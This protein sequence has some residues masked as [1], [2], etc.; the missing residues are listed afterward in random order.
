MNQKKLSGGTVS[1]FYF[2]CGCC[3]HEIF[4]KNG[5]T[6]SNSPK[7][8]RVVLKTTFRHTHIHIYIYIHIDDHF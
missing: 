8:T 4:E 6:E 1:N 2:A 5:G 3:R 7:G